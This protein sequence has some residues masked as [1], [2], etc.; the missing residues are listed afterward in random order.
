MENSVLVAIKVTIHLQEHRKNVASTKKRTTITPFVD[1]TPPDDDTDNDINMNLPHIWIRRIDNSVHA[2]AKT[3]QK[4]YSEGR[5]LM[6]F[7]FNNYLH[8]EIC[9]SLDGADTADAYKNGLEFFESKGHL[10][11]FIRIDNVTSPHL[12]L[13]LLRRTF[14]NKPLKLKYVNVGDHRRNKAEKSIQLMERAYLST[15]ASMDA[16]FPP[17]RRLTILPLLEITVNHLVGWSANTTVSAWHG[18]HGHRYDFNAYPFTIAGC[19]VSRHVDKSKKLPTGHPKAS[20]Y[21][22]LPSRATGAYTQ[23]SKYPPP[24]KRSPPLTR[25]GP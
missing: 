10:V 18:L 5:Y 24:S 4:G 21:F 1:S 6:H 8:I 15:I 25:L 2:D 20:N 9:N 23:R 14:S 12:R 22:R 16:S 11:D 7:V 13:T 19:L 3:L 17:A